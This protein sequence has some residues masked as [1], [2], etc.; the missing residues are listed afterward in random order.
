MAKV[1][2]YSLEL[3]VR[4]EAEAEGCEDLELPE[5]AEDLEAQARVYLKECGVNVAGWSAY[6]QLVN[7]DTVEVVFEE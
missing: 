7:H 5:N 2:G 3:S 4:I 1:V 6:S